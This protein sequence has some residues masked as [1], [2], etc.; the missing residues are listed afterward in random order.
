MAAVPVIEEAELSD[1]GFRLLLVIE[2]FARL[3][4]FCYP[5]VET[6]AGKL[7]RDPRNV[8]AIMLELEQRGWIKRVHGARNELLGLILRRRA[9][10]ESLV[11][12][13]PDRIEQAEAAIRSLRAASV[14]PD[15]PPAVKPDEISRPNGRAGRNRPPKPDE[16]SRPSR[17]KSSA[18]LDA[19]EREST[20][21]DECVA[22][23]HKT[24][25]RSG[26]D[27]EDVRRAIHLL[28]T[29]PETETIGAK[30]EASMGSKRL[31]GIPGW[32]WLEASNRILG[33]ARSASQRGSFKYLTAIAQ[34]LTE[35]ER[36]MAAIPAE[37]SERAAWFD[38]AIRGEL[39]RGAKT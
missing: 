33:P 13:T 12:D 29:H 28:R 23:P 7:H 9:D 36:P 3:S 34:D 38:A 1:R 32:K 30:L 26:Q 17:T 6:L 8:R 25:L 5:S 4:C 27:L 39:N 16:I 22:H 31:A 10:T 2:S 11:A 35:A 15:E 20:E 21:L 18:E 19:F 24:G 14:R 37:P